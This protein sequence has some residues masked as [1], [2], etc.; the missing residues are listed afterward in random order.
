MDSI[1]CFGIESIFFS[2]YTFTV[3]SFSYNILPYP[4]TWQWTDFQGGTLHPSTVS[5][6]WKIRFRLY[7]GAIL[8]IHLRQGG[9]HGPHHRVPPETSNGT[10]SCISCQMP[11]RVIDYLQPIHINKD[12]PRH[13]YAPASTATLHHCRHSSC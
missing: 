2:I 1:T 7:V 11:F 9:T 12:T 5:A 3:Y 4:G 13:N 8:Q 6:D 10:K